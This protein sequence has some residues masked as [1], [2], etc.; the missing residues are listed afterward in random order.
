MDYHFAKLLHTCGGHPHVQF[1]A[2]LVSFELH[3]G[4]CCIDVSWAST[5]PN[6]H[7]KLFALENAPTWQTY[8]R[9]CR[10]LNLPIYVAFCVSTTSIYTLHAIGTMKSKSHI[11]S[12]RWHRFIL[13]LMPQATSELPPHFFTQLQQTTDYRTFLIDHLDIIAPE[14]LDW[15][16]IEHVIHSAKTQDGRRTQPPS[17]L[18]IPM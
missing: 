10:H 12:V 4:H 6:Q 16:A 17:F 7:A 18:I 13:I 14:H 8:A 5:I 11:N 9:L 1:L 2:A 15:P 3:Q